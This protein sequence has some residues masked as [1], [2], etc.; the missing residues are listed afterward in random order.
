MKNKTN[1]QC[2]E[3]TIATTTDPF[4]VSFDCACD[5]QLLYVYCAL[6]EYGRY[7][8]NNCL[9]EQTIDNKKNSSKH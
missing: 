5:D 9:Q 6:P 2:D 1:K 8:N 3:K 7:F 4:D